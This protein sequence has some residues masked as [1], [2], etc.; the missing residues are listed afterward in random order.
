M[1]LQNGATKSA[2]NAINRLTVISADKDLKPVYETV[3]KEMM[4]CYCVDNE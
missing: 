2:A 4:I 1:A 3:I